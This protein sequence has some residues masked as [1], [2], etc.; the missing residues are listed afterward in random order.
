MMP[1]L[2]CGKRPV[3]PHHERAHRLEVVDRG[4][5]AEDVKLLASGVV[6]KLRLVAEREERLRAA[7]GRAC[8]SDREDLVCG[9]IRGLSRPRPLGE[10]AIVAD[11]TTEMGK[12]NE[13][14][15]RIREMAA[16]PLV[17]QTARGVDQFRE[18]GLFEP[19]RKR[20]VARIAHSTTCEVVWRASTL[21]MASGR[22]MMWYL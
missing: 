16:M 5:I 13:H 14:L 22:R 21:G 3:S 1:G 20:F 9:K 15:A 6:A 4:R 10:S 7:G 17:A 11:I 12:W 2:A 8:A 18:R 19:D